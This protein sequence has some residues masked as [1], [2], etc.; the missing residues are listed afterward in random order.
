MPDTDQLLRNG[1]FWI[2]KSQAN[3]DSMVTASYMLQMAAVELLKAVV[4]E[5]QNV[6]EEL[7]RDRR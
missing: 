1:E 7:A 3:T 2:S 6:R 5:L 4:S